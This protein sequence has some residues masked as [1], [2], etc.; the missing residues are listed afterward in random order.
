M[1]KACFRFMM[2]FVFLGGTAANHAFGQ[3]VQHVNPNLPAFD[4]KAATLADIED[5]G[6]K[7]LS[8]AQAMPADKYAWRPT[9]EGSPSI[10]EVYVLAATQYYHV[11]SEWGLLK[12]AGYEADGDLVTGNREPT[13]P[14]EKTTKDKAQVINELFDATSYF[15]GISR[16]LSDAD[17]QKPIK[18]LGHDT[19]PGASLLLLDADLHAYLDEAIVYARMNGIV[20]P[21][22]TEQ[23]KDREAR[24]HRTEVVRGKPQ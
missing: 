20:L 16:T 10:S 15:G 17:L 12:A 23:E 8:I 2:V 1:M 11:P 14:L 4:F 18:F 9:G 5:M 6:K 22:M 7:L 21:W 13:Q 19:T 3:S 24:G